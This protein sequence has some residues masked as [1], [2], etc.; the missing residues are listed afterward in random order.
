MRAAVGLREEMSRA[1]AAAVERARRAEE[2]TLDESLERVRDS[3][4]EQEKVDIEKQR[5]DAK[6]ARAKEC[7]RARAEAQR[8]SERQMR[9]LQ[10]ELEQDTVQAVEE[11]LVRVADEHEKARAEVIRQAQKFA[12]EGR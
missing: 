11:E 10:A 5:V 7:R 2:A 9:K 6:K 4:K 3:V 1:H 8:D 12:Q